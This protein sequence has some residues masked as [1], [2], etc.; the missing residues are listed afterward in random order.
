MT[1]I[2][3]V[4]GMPVPEHTGVEVEHSGRAFRFCTKFC[5]GLLQR[6]ERIGDPLIRLPGPDE[7]SPP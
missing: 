6:L 1:G 4:C 7:E 5:K 3:P 2:D